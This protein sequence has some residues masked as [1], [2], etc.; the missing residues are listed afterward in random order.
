M[1]K[2]LCRSSDAE[3]QKATFSQRLGLDAGS[4]IVGSHQF[5]FTIA[6]P[7]V[8]T[9]S[10]PP[11]DDHRRLSLS[12][13]FA[14]QGAPYGVAYEIIARARRGRLHSDLGY[15][16]LVRAASAGKTEDHARLAVDFVYFPIIRP[17]P[18]SALRQAV[19]EQGHS[20]LPG[21]HVDPDGWTQVRTVTINGHLF[22]DR[23]VEV[24]CTVRGVRVNLTV[25]PIHFSLSISCG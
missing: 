19:Y 24:A 9:I 20:R 2:V 23:Y 10:N 7:R 18:F 15:V 17:P 25:Y 14:E 8:S 6:L 12:S 11:S 5:P 1:S 13:S 3:P 21:P 22:G 16:Y 4:Q